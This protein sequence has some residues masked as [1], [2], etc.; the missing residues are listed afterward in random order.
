MK[1]T[2]VETC[3]GLL[4]LLN[5]QIRHLRF[6]AVE[7]RELDLNENADRAEL[8]LATK[9]KQDDALAALI[10]HAEEERR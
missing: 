4:Q 6:V 1:A 10:S 7:A 2:D 8:S 3:R 5:S 9:A